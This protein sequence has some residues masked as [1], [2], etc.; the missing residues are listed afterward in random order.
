MADEQV[1]GLLVRSDADRPVFKAPAPKTS[2]LG[3]PASMRVHFRA[4]STPIL[5]LKPA[6][7]QCT[8]YYTGLDK[9]AQQKRLESGQL[10]SALGMRLPLS[11]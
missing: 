5:R 8:C 11:L 6:V 2:L 4:T 7:A 9:L 3:E 10:Q 1:G